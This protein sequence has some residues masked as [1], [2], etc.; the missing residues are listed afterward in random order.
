MS[1]LHPGVYV[2]EVS[3]GVRVVEGVP[4]STTIFVG[5]T[6]RGPINPVKI[7]GIADYERA[8]GS[9]LRASAGNPVPVT[10]RYAVGGF[11]ANGGT[12]AYVLR[13][14]P[15]SSAPA[16]RAFAAIVPATTAAFDAATPG[17]WANGHLSVVLV[18]SSSGVVTVARILVFYRDLRQPTARRSLVEDFDRLRIG[19]DSA[20]NDVAQVLTRSSFI[21]WAPGLTAC[22]A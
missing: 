16:R 3:S 5:E 13:A 15:A 12:S 4:T 17:V 21:R 10:M 7:K 1:M 18:P 2:R 6:E 22:S 8:F 11:F 20:E 9:F 19:G 14:V